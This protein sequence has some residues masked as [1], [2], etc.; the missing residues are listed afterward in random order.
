MVV[1]VLSSTHTQVVVTLNITW[2]ISCR[3]TTPVVV[4][5]TSVTSAELQPPFFDILFPVWFWED[6]VQEK[7]GSWSRHSWAL[8]VAVGCEVLCQ[9]PWLASEEQAC[10]TP[11]SVSHSIRRVPPQ[12]QGW[13]GREQIW[14]PC[15]SHCPLSAGSRSTLLT[16]GQTDLYCQTN[17]GLVSL[18]SHCWAR[19]KSHA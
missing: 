10:C 18:R 4:T 19:P 14:L 7:S 1:L 12:P 13:R 11:A 2:V 17:P 3:P 16:V 9:L 6:T 5:L 15:F 8:K